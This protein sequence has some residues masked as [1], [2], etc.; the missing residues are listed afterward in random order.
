MDV[1]KISQIKPLY[2]Y[3]S[4]VNSE[5]DDIL[6]NYVA[7]SFQWHKCYGKIH[8][9]G[10]TKKDSATHAQKS[11]QFHA[12]SDSDDFDVVMWWSMKGARCH[13]APK[14]RYSA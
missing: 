2:N 11:S 9:R 5:T 3:N 1:K 12:S 14:E 8:A 7:S 4:K 6:A 10:N 13:D